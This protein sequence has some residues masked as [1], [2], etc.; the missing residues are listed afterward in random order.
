MTPGHA[1]GGGTRRPPCGSVNFNS[2]GST[3]DARWIWSGDILMDLENNTAH[4]IMPKTLNGSDYLF[5]E[6]GGFSPRNPPG[7]RSPLMVIRRR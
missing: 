3:N 4:K 1:P 6:S 7:W 2:D 5:I